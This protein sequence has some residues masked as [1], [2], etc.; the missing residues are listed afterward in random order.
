LQ[1]TCSN[2]RGKT[3]HPFITDSIP[4]LFSGKTKHCRIRQKRS[5]RQQQAPSAYYLSATITITAILK[6]RL[7][8]TCKLASGENPGSYHADQ[9]AALVESLELRDE[10]KELGAVPYAALQHLYRNC[11][12][13]ATPAYAETFAHP[14]VEAMASGLPVIASDLP[15][16]REICGD[17]ALYF[18]RFSAEDLADRIMRVS[19]SAECQ[20][21]M[22][23]LGLS[24]SRD[25]SWDRH[26]DQLVQLARRMTTNPAPVQ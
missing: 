22:R 23:Q 3:C 8:L 20:K 16:H 17:A 6:I 7:I 24:R 26:V 9:A 2:G 4:E 13:Y 14:L 19:G 15:V 11:D 5:L 12:V 18:P 1:Q 25:F 21:E 10:V